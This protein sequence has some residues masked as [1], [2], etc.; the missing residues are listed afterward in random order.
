MRD[1]LKDKIAHLEELEIIEK[2][3]NQLSGLMLWSYVQLCINPVDLSK[4]IKHPY[5][6]ISTFDD[7]I[8]NL[9]RNAYFTKR[10]A[11]SGY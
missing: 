4:A 11:Q 2:P 9:D 3:A 7:G 5:C 8:S 10:D 1:K 6:P